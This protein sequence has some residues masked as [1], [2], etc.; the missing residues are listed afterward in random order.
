MAQRKQTP[1]TGISTTSAYDDGATCS[2]VNLRP[3]N[4]AL[5]PVT[6]RKAKQALSRQYD[7]IFVHKNNDYENWVGVINGAGS[8][9]VYSDIRN[10]SPQIVAQVDGV[11]GSV[12]QIG[13]TLSLI[14]VDN[15]S[16]LLF[17]NGAYR[18]LGELPQIP[19]ISF[20][21]VEDI[22]SMAEDIAEEYGNGVRDKTDGFE[23]EI[24]GLA[25]KLMDKMVNGYTNDDNTYVDGNGPMLFDAHF[26]RYAFRLYDGTL[27]KHSPPILVMPSVNPL[28]LKTVSFRTDG[29]VV[30]SVWGY[31]VEI[32]C[33]TNLGGDWARWTDIIQSVDIFMSAPLGFANVENLRSDL[34]LKVNSSNDKTLLYTFI[35]DTS[36][37]KQSVADTSLFYLVREL[38]LG[39]GYLS[40]EIPTQDTTGAK[41]NFSDMNNLIH[42]EVMADDQFSNHK[43]G[44]NTSYSYNSRLHLADITT[45]FFKGFSADYFQ[46]HGEYNESPNFTSGE[47]TP[48]QVPDTPHTIIIEVEI[49]VGNSI[50]RVYTSYESHDDPYLYG[51]AFFSYPDP[52][53][54]RVTIYGVDLYDTSF[55]ERR[56]TAALTPHKLLNLAYCMSD[57]FKPITGEDL[58]DYSPRDT[59]HVIT[60]SEPNKL[61][62]S[63]LNNPLVFPVVNTYQIGDG[64]ILALASNAMN[65]S[66]RNYGQYPLYIFTNKG[67]W[68]LNVG[69]GEVAYSTLSAPVSVETPVSKIVCETPYGVAFVAQM[70]LMIING[71]SV[72]FISPQ[73]EEAPSLMEIEMNGPCYGV[74]FSPERVKFSDILKGLRDMVYDPHENELIINTGTDLNYVLNFPSRSFWQSTEKIDLVVKNAYPDLFVVGDSQLKDYA[75]AQGPL[76]HVGMITRPIQFGMPNIKRLE[77]MILRG[78]IYGAATTNEGKRALHMFH[79]SMDRVNFKAI[80]GRLM[81]RGNHL[82]LDSG[83]L[84]RA[85]SSYFM[86]TLA[87]V[88]DEKTEIRYLDSVFDKEYDNTKM[89]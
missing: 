71:Q 19:A 11:V 52:R 59:S 24:K 28:R 88:V 9:T 69:S 60:L 39:Q 12:Q 35:E 67:I 49:V 66:D 44:A 14:T 20:N 57:Q 73:I 27:T 22:F 33:D 32:S 7:I 40:A 17:H 15:V 65:V 37:L 50:E 34:P 41:I 16:Y 62:V 72:D 47:S 84:S 8:A 38:S 25:N 77:R 81:Q 13:N 48:P 46:W 4:G 31:R 3:K 5:H 70:G 6:P 21:T 51:G 43:Y 26:I 53:A 18:H 86:F 30:V 85:K 74:V 29:S 89:R 64:E 58:G 80:T 76:A 55:W 2:L 68:A 23:V 63:E 75:A 78:H 54:Q 10:A 79:H 45:T 42:Q 61:K 36:E 83:L 56:F 1:I 87:G 82:D